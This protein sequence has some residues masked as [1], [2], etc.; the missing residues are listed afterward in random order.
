VD[1]VGRVA[2]QIGGHGFYASVSVSL[3]PAA[4]GHVE[5][6]PAADDEWQRSQGWSGA[7]VAG[8][9]LGLE[10]AGASG[11]CVVTRVHGMVCDTSPGLV[12]LA[13]V[14][15]AWAAVSFTPA[16]PLAEAVERCVLRGHQLSLGSL[17]AELA[18]PTKQADPTVADDGRS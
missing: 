18:V 17:R 6:A 4:K 13:G 11:R 3:T 2:K 8:V 5:L 1:A 9:T 10:L 14:R 16:P 12:A 7:A 15:A